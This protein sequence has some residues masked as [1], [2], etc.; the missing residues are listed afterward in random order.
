M[1]FAP[2]HV[3]LHEAPSPPD[4][5]SSGQCTVALASTLLPW[6]CQ[7]RCRSGFWHSSPPNWLWR[8]RKPPS[9]SA[10]T[11]SD[12]AAP[13]CRVSDLQTSF[14]LPKHRARHAVSA[15]HVNVAAWH[16]W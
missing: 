10:A 3:T 5:G 8:L 2:V 13:P 14:S 1:V 15:P 16:A 11:A 7:Q 12:A 9:T 6:Y 4:G